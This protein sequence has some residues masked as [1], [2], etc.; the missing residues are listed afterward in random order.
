LFRAVTYLLLEPEDDLGADLGAE[1]RP[2]LEPPELDRPALEDLP[3][4]ELEGARPTEVRLG[5]DDLERE[6]DAVGLRVDGTRADPVDRRDVDGAVR[7]TITGRE[8]LVPLR[9]DGAVRVTGTR[10]TDP[11]LVDGIDRPDTSGD[12]RVPPA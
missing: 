10:L 7:G 4:D 2:E 5:E 1:E 12:P 11:R 3:V 6:A 8:V 9:V